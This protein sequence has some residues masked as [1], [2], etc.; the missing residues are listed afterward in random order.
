MSSSQS[1]QCFILTSLNTISL[2][3][4]HE[5]QWVPPCSIS[6]TMQASSHIEYWALFA[7][8]SIFNVP[9]VL[10]SHWFKLVDDLAELFI[11]IAF[12]QS[13]HLVHYSME[14]RSNEI[15]F[16]W[17]SRLQVR[18]QP[19]QRS[20]WLVSCFMENRSK[21]VCHLWK[22]FKDHKKTFQS[23][24]CTSHILSTYL[25]FKGWELLAR[26]GE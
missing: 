22:I 21:Y 10:L 17:L 2:P 14:N 6:I 25:R 16:K 7:L 19:T 11:Q 1:K 26:G 18:L 24:S 23:M 12:D 20:K 4:M 5:K 8:S 3:C 15:S 9:S 13:N